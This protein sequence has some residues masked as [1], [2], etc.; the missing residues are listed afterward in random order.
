MKS[1]GP[2]RALLIA[3]LVMAGLV[4]LSRDHFFFWDTVQ[5]ASM[6]AHWYF[7]NGFRYFFLP[8]NIDSGHPPSFG[9]Y[10]ALCWTAF[11]RSLAVSH[12]AMLP[13]L[14]G[15]LILIKKIGQQLAGNSWLWLLL[16]VMA[17]PVFLGQA[18]LVSPDLV[19][20]FF[21][22]LLLLGIF[23]KNAF[24]ILIGCVGL[25]IISMRGMMTAAALFTW[26]FLVEVQKMKGERSKEK[27]GGIKKEN[28]DLL[29]ILSK[30]LELIKPFL[31][32]A[33]LGFA[34]LVAHYLHAGWIG[35]HEESPWA[36]S[37]ARVGGKALVF[38]AATLVWRMLDYGR[39]IVVGV[40]IWRI[41]RLIFRKS[42]F[43]KNEFSVI[44]LVLVLGLFLL[45]GLLL[46]A[47]LS[48]HRYFLPIFVGMHLWVFIIIENLSHK[49]KTTLRWLV[50]L[51]LFSG[52]FWIYPKEI[53]QGWDS[54]LAHWPYYELREEMIGYMRENEVPFEET[55]T[56]FP[57]TAS[58][59]YIDLE[60]AD[61]QFA[62]K[63]LEANA[64]FFYSTVYNGLSDEE[65]RLLEEAWSIEHQLKKWGIEVILYKK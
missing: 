19:L 28:S 42:S 16:F 34:F 63:D 18:V 13:F 55:G 15:I 1:N 58:F 64:Y 21:M 29:R 39:F 23:R 54:T 32:G 30:A 17:D 24:F 40:L 5:L 9:A 50:L 20:L 56:V 6:Q 8:E 37:F 25:C 14:I 45:P 53:S 60:E 10:L 47:G 43:F 2:D 38:N 31:P 48:A 4:W 41:W 11:G 59:R 57:N 49:Y 62:L 36:P 12:F 46:H 33:F 22:L 26:Q 61:T 3:G 7:D 44:S 52:H 51:I 65:F 27:T 35:Y